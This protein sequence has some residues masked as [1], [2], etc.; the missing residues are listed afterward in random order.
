MRGRK[1]NAD[2]MVQYDIREAKNQKIPAAALPITS[3]PELPA[4]G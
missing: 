2:A 4:A 3:A 1:K